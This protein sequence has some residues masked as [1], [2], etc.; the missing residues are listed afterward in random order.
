[1]FVSLVKFDFQVPALH[2]GFMWN[3]SQTAWTMKDTVTHAITHN[4]TWLGMDLLGS[5]IAGAKLH[6]NLSMHDSAPVRNAILVACA[7]DS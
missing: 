6:V 1:M 5:L 7:Y 2:K 3:S 4:I